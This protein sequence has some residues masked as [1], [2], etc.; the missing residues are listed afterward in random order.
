MQG[1]LNGVA[2][3]FVVCVSGCTPIDIK[4]DFDSTVDFSRFKTFAFT[5]TTDPNQSGV[6]DNPLVRDRLEAMIDRELRQ[7]GLTQTRSDQHPDL[8]V[9]YWAGVQDK[10]R[11]QSNPGVRAYSWGDGYG[12]GAGSGRVA[13][14]EYREGT[15]I[16]DLVE[17]TNKTLVWR[18]TMVTDLKD[19][20]NE[21]I[22]LSDKAIKKAF[23]NYPPSNKK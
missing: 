4:T 21:N 10:Q 9:H 19:S 18:A 17:P 22:E 12:W 1:W 6:L 3:I 7:K 13:T 5:G 8:L 20:V 15:L 14:F 23:E 16:T 11:Q 2:A